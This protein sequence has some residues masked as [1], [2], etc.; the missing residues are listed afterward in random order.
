MR[1]TFDEARKFCSQTIEI[2]FHLREH[3]AVCGTNSS[4]S[5]IKAQICHSLSGDCGG[6]GSWSPICQIQI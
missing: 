1:L 2:N 4:A 3:L 5:G 6:G